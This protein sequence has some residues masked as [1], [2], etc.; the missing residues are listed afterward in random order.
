MTLWKKLLLCSVSFMGVWA[1]GKAVIIACADEPDPYDY[2]TSFFHPE[3]QGQKD[4]GA[5]YFTDYQFTYG[6]EEPVSEAAVNAA[7]WAQYLGAPVKAADVEKVMYHLDS[8]GKESA[9]RFVDQDQPP[10]DSLAQ[11]SFLQAL[12]SPA[13]A[14]ARKYYQF[15]QQAERLGQSGYNYWEPS[16][17]D[18]AGLA[19]D[20]EH[21]LQAALSQRDSFLKLRYLY[22]AQ[23]LHHY[24]GNYEQAN[25]I[26]DQH[27]AKLPAKSHVKGWALSLKAGEQRRLGDTTRAAYLFSKVFA[28]YPER[29]LQAYRNYHY[30]GAPLNEVLKL[31]ATPQEKANLYAIEGFANPELST[32]Y[33]ENVY[34]YAPSS[35]LVGVLLVREI[36]K[37]EEYYLT[38]KLANNTETAYSSK[39][40]HT[41]TPVA[42]Q[43]STAKW[44]LLG[45]VFILLAGIALLM[46]VI[47]KR[48]AQLAG[49]IS[50][51]VLIA[52]GLAGVAWFIT[53][54]Y[55]NNKPVTPIKVSQGS[56]FVNLPDSVTTQ[57]DDHIEKL[58]NF[59]KQLGADNKYPEPQ[60]GTL[61][62]AYL[63]FIQNK[64]E[65]GLAVLKQMG[66]H[67]TNEKLA[68]QKQI[69]SL[70]LSAQKLKQVQ[71]VDEAAL[72]PALQ[73]L[74]NKVV[75]NP[76]PKADVYPETPDNHNR[77]AITERNFYTHVLA[78]AYLRQGDTAKAALVMLKSNYGY[79]NNYNSYLDNQL[80]DFWFNYLHSAQV[81]QLLDWKLKRPSYPYL[82]FLSHS[83]KA[84]NAD[85]L[86]ELLGTTGLREHQYA[87]AAAAFKQMKSNR[88]KNRNYNGE[89][90]YNTGENLQGDPFYVEI[91]DYP[92]AFTGT[93]YTKL[94]FAQKMAALQ[95]QLKANPQ[96]A[97]VYYQMANALYNTS[98]YGNSWGLITY[99]W[100]A[101]DYGR[102]P[103]YDYDADYTQASLAK[104]YYLKAR[105]LSNNAELKA[106]CTF[107]AAKCEQ[108]QHERPSYTDYETY[109]KREKAFIQSLQKNSYFNEMRAYRSTAFYR[110]AVE[111]CS[112][113]RDFLKANP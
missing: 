67:T 70:L 29:R 21:A 17:L 35:P 16:P 31:A 8:A 85:K 23:K 15:A 50:G 78:P 20:A 108:K 43:L 110:Q 4:F 38:P 32:T 61:T 59:C 18:T 39:S 58:Q 84:V 60:I 102:K 69:I 9:F 92:K 24:A 34:E 63:H 106:R 87:A 112:Y 57:Y 95:S 36:N 7:E 79:A 45:S 100:S 104:Q 91:N 105:A 42:P 46:F 5:F 76:K 55:S 107:M 33:L 40:Q 19:T 83:L 28:S 3:I 27:I 90:F 62:S 41:P 44:V 99:S 13:Q 81:R 97:S 37:L 52:A 75:N 30:I 48:P 88:L 14:E 6:L 1:A 74:H 22:Q 82:A 109:D 12:K 47:K 73:W 96:N 94:G 65:D 101:L 89:D 68:E 10:A 71:Q 2:Y 25:Q 66:N 98:T 113:L 54:R 77:F 103:L 111:E 56:F 86:Y 80:P 93:R 72:L 26:Y 53:S 11:S 51:G 49:K 64:P